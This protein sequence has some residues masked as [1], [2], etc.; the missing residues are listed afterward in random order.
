MRE[1]SRLLCFGLTFAAIRIVAFGLSVLGY[2]RVRSALDVLVRPRPGPRLAVDEARD[3]A[4]AVDRL[5]TSAA[6]GVPRVGC[7]PRSLLTSTLLAREGIETVVRIGVR[8]DGGILKAHAWV[9]HLGLPLG[10]PG[11]VT[12]KFAPFDRDFGSG[13]LVR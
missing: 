6:R 9:E 12:A 4:S 2:G 5:V 3:R 8:R 11:D 7:L 13:A 1:P 10:D